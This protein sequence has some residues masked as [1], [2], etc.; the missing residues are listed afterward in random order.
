MTCILWQKY[1]YIIF[2]IKLEQQKNKIYR[3]EQT[4]SELKAPDVE[5]LRY[6]DKA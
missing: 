2:K 3:I 4:S 1:N 6:G 5:C